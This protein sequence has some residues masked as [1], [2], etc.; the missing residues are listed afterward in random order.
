M[1][2]P[3]PD[4]FTAFKTSTYKLVYYQTA[5]GL[6]FVMTTSPNME[7]SIIR[8]ALQHIYSNFFLEF[9]VK[10]PLLAGVDGEE[11]SPYISSGLF[12]N[13]VQKFVRGLPGFD[14]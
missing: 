12:N 11:A 2:F 1:F 3:R 8:E 4:S 5:S 9:V 6:K 14:L 10:N 13:A 7:T